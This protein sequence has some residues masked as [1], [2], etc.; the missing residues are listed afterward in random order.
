[1]LRE[2]GDLLAMNIPHAPIGFIGLG[3]M[4]EPMALNLAKAGHRLVVWNRSPAKCK[5]VAALGAIVAL[6]PEEVFLRCET[7]I[8][9]LVDGTALDDVLMRHG[10]GFNERVRGRTLINMAT[11]APEYS[12]ALEADIIAA[13]GR[14]VEAPVSGSRRPAEA[15]QLIGMLAGQRESMDAVRPLLA[16]MCSKV[17]PCGDVPNALLMKLSVNLFL[18]AVVAGLAESVH[19]ASRQN[20]DLRSFFAVLD[21]GPLASDVSRVKGEK[22]LAQDFSIQASIRNVLEN[23]QLISGAARGAG[24]ASPLLDVC[25]ALF[26]ETSALGFADSDMIAVIR[27][28]EHRTSALQSL[29]VNRQT[30]I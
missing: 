1:M 16:P 6:S 23:V 28:I 13:G 2:G 20:L 27:A 25:L 30:E 3:A 9:M 15:G 7:V 4:G 5:G 21:A 12:K 26:T 19:F 8:V 22:F 17:V 29:D 10:R 14:Y 11:T 24:A 18:T